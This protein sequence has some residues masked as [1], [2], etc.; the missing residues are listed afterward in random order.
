MQHVV[1]CKQQLKVDRNGLR[2]SSKSRS[3]HQGQTLHP[4]SDKP[5]DLNV[6][7]AKQNTVTDSAHSLQP[8]HCPLRQV[9]AVHPCGQC[10]QS[11]LTWRS[12][13]YRSQPAVLFQ[14]P[15]G[16]HLAVEP[17]ARFDIQVERLFDVHARHLPKGKIKTGHGG[18][19]QHCQIRQRRGPPPIFPGTCVEASKRR[20]HSRLQRTIGVVLR[21][22]HFTC[23]TDHFAIFLRH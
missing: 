9:A 8:T 23:C 20:R 10:G 18:Q 6:V 14:V 21:H 11:K 2:Q 1:A 22:C 13:R 3:L 12:C 15:L 4:N 19:S 7:H 5:F 17:A 16:S